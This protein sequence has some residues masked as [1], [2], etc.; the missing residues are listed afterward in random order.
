MLLRTESVVHVQNVVSTDSGTLKFNY[1]NE[2][3]HV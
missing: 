2:G 3:G 1:C